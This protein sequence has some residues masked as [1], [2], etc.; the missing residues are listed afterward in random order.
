[1]GLVPCWVVNSAAFGGTPPNGAR[2]NSAPKSEITFFQR[3][4]YWS[5]FASLPGM[6]TSLKGD[7]GGLWTLGK[8]K[9]THTNQDIQPPHPSYSLPL[10]ADTCHNVLAFKSC[11]SLLNVAGKLILHKKKQNHR[12]VKVGR[13]LWRSSRAPLCTMPLSYKQLDSPH[14]LLT[15][16]ALHHPPS[17]HFGMILQAPEGS[18]SCG[19][20]ELH[21]TDLRLCETTQNKFYDSWTHPLAGVCCLFWETFWGSAFT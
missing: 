13:D 8:S 3:F 6:T 17:L 1:M 11:T 14:S 15:K 5:Y 9:H 21:T 12:M 10:S 19:Q 7:S 18:V 16:E 2:H 20:R 4:S